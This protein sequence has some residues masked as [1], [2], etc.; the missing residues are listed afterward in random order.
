[1]TKLANDHKNFD[2]IKNYSVLSFALFSCFFF[3]IYILLTKNLFI[4]MHSE[5]KE[6]L[7]YI[8]LLFLELP[9][10][11]FIVFGFGFFITALSLSIAKRKLMTKA[12]GIVALL[13]G[14]M[15]GIYV[16]AMFLPLML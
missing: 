15:F 6:P 13:I 3:A 10:W 1:M 4:S 2:G 12:F 14:F 5:M 16:L 8:T 7:P 11:L 9:L